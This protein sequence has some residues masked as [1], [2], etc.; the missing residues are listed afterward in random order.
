MLCG[1]K[2][3]RLRGERELWLTGDIDGIVDNVSMLIHQ[4]RDIEDPIRSRCFN[5]ETQ[6]APPPAARD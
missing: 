2:L 3:R 6:N 5:L 1:G 4:F